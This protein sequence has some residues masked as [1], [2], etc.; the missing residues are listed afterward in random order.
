[1]TEEAREYI[2]KRL[3]AGHPIEEIKSTLRN[4][5]WDENVISE[6]VNSVQ[7]APRESQHIPKP[8]PQENQTTPKTEQHKSNKMII[9]I[10]VIAVII[11]VVMF[12]LPIIF[13]IFFAIGM[14]NPDAVE[15]EIVTGFNSIGKPEKGGWTYS[16][17]D[18]TI[19]FTNNAGNSINIENATAGDCN[20][21]NDFGEVLKNEG[22]VLSFNG[23]TPLTTGTHYSIKIYIRGSTDTGFAFA[24]GGFLA[25]TA[26]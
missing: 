12:V 3:E 5:G 24:D 15:G 25:S 4:A 20:P 23:C 8:S 9:A 2:R 19:S 11:V 26:V 1:M 22:F 6:A 10:I 17:S 7:Q 21:I 14:F 13:G 16:G 18:L